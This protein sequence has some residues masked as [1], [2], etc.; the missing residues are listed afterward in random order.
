P[1][2]MLHPTPQLTQQ[3]TLRPE[4]KQIGKGVWEGIYDWK[5]GGRKLT[6]RLDIQ[7]VSD[8]GFEGTL[9]VPEYGDGGSKYDVRGE[10]YSATEQREMKKWQLI[11]GFNPSEA[12]MKFRLTL[13]KVLL[14]P[15]KLGHMLKTWSYAIIHPNGQIEGVRF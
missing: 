11:S 9:Y 13:T 6:W 7:R 15:P 8:T 10:F 12:V 5:A 1:Q 2:K 3:P 14:S 4:A